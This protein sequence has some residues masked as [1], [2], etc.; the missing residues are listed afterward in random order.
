MFTASLWISTASLCRRKI[1]KRHVCMT[2]CHHYSSA[3]VKKQVAGP[4]MGVT[5]KTQDKKVILKIVTSTMDVA[6]ILMHMPKAGRR[7]RLVGP[8]VS[9]TR[10]M[11]INHA[12]VR[13]THQ[14]YFR[15]S[16]ANMSAA[17][18]SAAAVQGESQYNNRVRGT[19]QITRNHASRMHAY[20]RN[21]VSVDWPIDKFSLDWSLYQEV[22]STTS[23]PRP[24]RQF[25]V[26]KD[27]LE[28]HGA[29]PRRIPVPATA[30][31]LVILR[32]NA[33]GLKKM[34]S[35]R[36]RFGPSRRLFNYR[37]SVC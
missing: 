24:R 9:V 21:R 18:A 12:Y 30:T 25:L 14:M 27:F 15:L 19:R 22:L 11:F 33:T 3:F 5:S 35:C 31:E 20:S 34:S 32:P 7:R 26:C 16:I 17:A 28:L 8:L 37:L 6:Q 13:E 1:F 2:T 36:E 29:K 23:L 4:L 10:L